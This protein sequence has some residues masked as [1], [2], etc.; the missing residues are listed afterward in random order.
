MDSKHRYAPVSA[1]TIKRG[2]LAVHKHTGFP[3]GT[4]P[5]CSPIRKDLFVADLTLA[6]GSH[7]YWGCSHCYINSELR[8]V[9]VGHPERDE[10]RQGWEEV[11]NDLRVDVL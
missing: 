8:F 5:G 4:A 7:R 2:M 6:D 10:I 3:P 11:P 1:M 9:I